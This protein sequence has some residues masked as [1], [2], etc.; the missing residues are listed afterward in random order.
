MNERKEELNTLIRKAHNELR[1]IESAE[2]LL[3]NLALVGKYFKYRNCYSCPES[4]SDYW[5]IYA[6]VDSLS[7]SNT[8]VVIQFQTDKYGMI[9]IETDKN[10]FT[11]SNGWTVI[12]EAEFSREWKK[13]KGHIDGMVK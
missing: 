1:D 2:R 11:M 12:S 13:I 5:W 9:T 10:Q 3:D 4:D 6:R 8:P 7:E